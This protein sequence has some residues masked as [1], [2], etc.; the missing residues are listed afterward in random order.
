M[1][2]DGILPLAA[3]LLVLAGA[4]LPTWGRLLIA[5]AWL[6][7]LRDYRAY[8]A[9]RPL[10]RAL[11]AADPRIALTPA[12]PVLLD[13]VAVRDLRFRLYRRVIEIRDGRLALMPYLDPD[14][15]AA[16]RVGRRDRRH[17]PG[18]GRGRRS[19]LLHAA[20][21]AR[22]AGTAAAREHA[23]DIP[24]GVDLDSDTAFLRDVARTFRELRARTRSDANVRQ[25][26]PP[27]TG[28]RK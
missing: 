18:A 28:A 13:L 2:P 20:L 5:P 7:W 1:L 9:L 27:R 24:G 16:A 6:A 21:R 4:T 22:A 19:R 15:A 3:H 25:V 10:W 23:P 17:R 14:V 8:Q 12:A 26:A 11:Y